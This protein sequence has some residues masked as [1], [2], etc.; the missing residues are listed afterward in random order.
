MLSTLRWYLTLKVFTL[1]MW[2]GFDEPAERW[3]RWSG[4]YQALRR[5]I[6]EAECRG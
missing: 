5:G 1:L 3:S 4:L 6:W 2:L